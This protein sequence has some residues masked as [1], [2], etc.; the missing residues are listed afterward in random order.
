MVVGSEGVRVCGRASSAGSRGGLARKRRTEGGIRGMRAQS[1]SE[2]SFGYSF[3]VDQYLRYESLTVWF[4][5][6]PYLR[7]KNA[8]SLSPYRLLSTMSVPR[9]SGPWTASQV[10]QQFF[11]YF[12]SKGHT[13]VPSSSTIPYDDPTLLFANAGMN[14]AC[15]LSPSPSISHLFISTSPYFWAPSI[16]NQTCPN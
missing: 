6:L 1:R 13:F 3:G 16:P 4:M 11:D 8:L 14:Q 2:S 9:Y 7:L 12:L 15:L 5:I 10:R